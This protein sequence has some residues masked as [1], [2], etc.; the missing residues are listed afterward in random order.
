MATRFPPTLIL[1]KLIFCGICFMIFAC[2]TLFDVVIN[3]CALN[4]ALGKL[5]CQ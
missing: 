2:T 4:N 1:A 5:V 3:P